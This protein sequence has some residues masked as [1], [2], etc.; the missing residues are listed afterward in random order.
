[1]GGT[2]NLSSAPAW[3]LHAFS[4]PYFGVDIV[5]SRPGYGSPKMGI[6]NRF[7]GQSPTPASSTADTEKKPKMLVVGFKERFSPRILLMAVIVSMGGFIFGYDTG[8]ISGFLE[9]PDFLARFS[10]TTDHV[11]GD[12][13][14]SNGRSGTIVALVCSAMVQ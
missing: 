7:R 11:T 12:L 8:Q 10:D 9:M 1:V 3:R 2:I 6:L 14:F 5:Q 4:L 13:K